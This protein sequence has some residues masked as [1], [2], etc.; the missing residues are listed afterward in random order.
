[1]TDDIF[2]T[3]VDIY[4]LNIYTE[5]FLPFTYTAYGIYFF[6]HKE[7]GTWYQ[8]TRGMYRYLCTAISYTG[9]GTIL[10]DVILAFL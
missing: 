5:I 7:P 10:C 3:L 2:V 1:M 8:T 9:T 4:I 6:L